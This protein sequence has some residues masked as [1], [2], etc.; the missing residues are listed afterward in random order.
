MAMAKRIRK[1]VASMKAT[2]VGPEAFRHL[3]EERVSMEVACDTKCKDF[4][5]LVG[6]HAFKILISGKDM[7]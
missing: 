6:K 1:T 4:W 5:R 2:H 7:T 3:I